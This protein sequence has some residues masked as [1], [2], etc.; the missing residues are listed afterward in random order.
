MNGVRFGDSHSYDDLRLILIEKEIGA[1]EPKLQSVEI[2]CADGILD[3]TDAFGGVR[4]SN[5]ALSFTFRCIEPYE[6]FYRIFSD[7]QKRIHGKRLRVIIDE[8]PGF[9]YLG[10]VSVD[11]WRA[12]KRIGEISVDVDAEPYKYAVSMTRLSFT[13]AE[14]GTVYLPNLMKP[15]KPEVTCSADMTAVF[16]GETYHF[17]SGAEGTAL[18]LLEGVNR[19]EIAGTGTISF[20][21]QEATL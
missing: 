21:Y 6:D 15:V 14:S 11:S 18:T 2:P 5:R 19:L 8:D 4:Y 9:Y 7:V 13:I 1:P 16:N 17:I 12:D 3:F 20:E 10:R